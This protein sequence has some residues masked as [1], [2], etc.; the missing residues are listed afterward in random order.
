MWNRKRFY[1][2]YFLERRRMTV[3]LKRQTDRGRQ[4]QTE[5]DRE[6][7]RERGR[8]G[9]RQTDRG[10][11]EGQRGGEKRNDDWRERERGGGEGEERERRE[12]TTGIYS[13]ERREKTSTASTSVFTRCR[14]LAS[15]G[16]R[17]EDRARVCRVEQWPIIVRVHNRY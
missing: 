12:M 7:Q 5:R 14:L 8:E 6:R 1:F 16:T 17:R 13:N 11:R 10:E 15:V 4:R 9:Q 3:E 2:I